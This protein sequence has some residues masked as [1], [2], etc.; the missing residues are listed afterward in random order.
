MN[1]AK[2]RG[3]ALAL[4]AV[5]LFGQTRTEAQISPT[6]DRN[7]TWGAVGTIALG[8]GAVSQ[9]VMPRMFYA[10]P[11]VTVGWKSRWHV[12]VLAP[13]A[14]LTMLGVLNELAIKDMLKSD[15]PGC[16]DTNRGLAHCDTYGSPSTHA[17]GAFAA[18]GHGVGV[19]LVDTT[20]WSG[21]KVTAGSLVGN[22]AIPF[23]AATVTAVSRGAGNWENT[24]QVLVG[25][26]AGLML[27]FVSGMA[28]SLMQR[29]EC[30]YSGSLMCW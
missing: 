6:P 4:T 2:R 26:T 17:Y 20:K 27:G 5:L 22:V 12:S 28:Y 16:D 8:L 23:I 18:L 19:F 24:G 10:D 3:L 14:T 25:G 15:R 9:L 1:K 13:V 11:E 7:T 29:P 30:G 21:G